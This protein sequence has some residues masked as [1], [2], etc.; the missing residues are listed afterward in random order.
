MSNKSK[1]FMLAGIIF[2]LVVPPLMSQPLVIKDVQVL[3]MEND[4]IQRNQTIIIEDGVIQW[5]GPDSEADYA[6]TSMIIEGDYYVLPGLAEMHA[7][8]P[9]SGQGREAMENTLAL[10]LTQGLTTIRGM[11][12]DPAHLELREEAE[13]TDFLSPRIFTSGPS[14]NGNSATDPETSRQMVRD[15]AEAGYDLLKLHPGITLEN[16]NA[17]AD[18]ANEQGIEFS[19]HI[20]EGIGLEHSLEAGQK[21]IEHFDKYMEFLT[22][23]AEK[24]SASVIYFGYEET[25]RVDLSFIDEAARI[26]NE[27]DAWVVPT[28]TLLENVF[29][30]DLTVG[31]MQDWPGMEYLPDDLVNGWSN[32]VRSTRNSP[33]YNEEQAREYLDIRKKLT[34]ALYE[35]GNRLL[36]GADAPQIFNPPGFAAHRE[37]EL[38]LESGL[39]PFEALET[40]TINV[41]RYIGEE[42]SVGKVAEGYRADLIL[43]DSNPLNSI[44]FQDH[45]QGVIYRGNYLDRAELNSILEGLR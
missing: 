14:F 36:L 44:P 4:Q 30:P 1:I 42:D 28:N 26:T 45:I 39:T 38:M 37:I 23:D 19:G 20:S 11:L 22:G 43:L 34:L 31:E 5:I 12:G 33:D 15:Q 21:T 25:P 6:N 32:F 9:S 27:A 29:N 41:G 2:F 7:H 10:Y 3:T 8:I 24:E 13:N 18:E 35:H 16:F 40:G 17:L